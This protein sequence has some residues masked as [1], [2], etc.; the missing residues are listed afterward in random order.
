[1]NSASAR[2]V[3]D[4][5]H[6]REV[7]KFAN[8]ILGGDPP[9]DPPPPPPPPRKP[10]QS[11]PGP[12]RHVVATAGNA[13]ARVSW[14]PAAANGSAITKYVVEA[15]GKTYDVGANQRSLE[16]TGLTNGQTYRFTVYA[17]NA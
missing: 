15:D 10:R 4:K 2:V 12:P 11:K 14:Q 17:V 6:V 7:N 13:T 8:D 1:P 3:D 16:I 5:H 9:K